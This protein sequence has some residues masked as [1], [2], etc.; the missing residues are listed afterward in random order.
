VWTNAA[1]KE[2]GFYWYRDVSGMQV[3]SADYGLGYDNPEHMVFTLPGQGDG[4]SA[5]RMARD[6]GEFWDAPILEPDK[7][8]RVLGEL[9]PGA[10]YALK[11]EVHITPELQTQLGGLLQALGAQTGCKFVLLG[12]GMDIQEPP[13]PRTWTREELDWPCECGHKFG[14]GHVETPPHKCVRCFKCQGFKK[15][16]VPQPTCPPHDLGPQD[17]ER[18]RTCRKCGEEFNV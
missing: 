14:E 12:P 18:V 9:R 15:A 10:T 13:G 8:P 2:P 11:V 5:Q 1:P 16:Y 3:I 17:G 4:F 6:Q 7:I